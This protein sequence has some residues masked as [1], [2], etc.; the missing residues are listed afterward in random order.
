LAAGGAAG[1]SLLVVA[2]LDSA[3]TLG[4]VWEGVLGGDA[5]RQR[6][7]GELGRDVLAAVP[8]AINETETSPWKGVEAASRRRGQG[9]VI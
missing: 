6:A 7:E 4:G 1:G 8:V 5:S 9:C 2:S 3:G